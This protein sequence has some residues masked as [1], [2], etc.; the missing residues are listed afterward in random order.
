MGNF[1]LKAK[2]AFK[3]NLKAIMDSKGLSYKDL[4]DMMGL[5]KGRVSALFNSESG[6]TLNT[7]EKV[8]AALSVE[9]TDL[10]DPNFKN[11]LK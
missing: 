7:V 5:T 4:G 9:E 1:S 11:K 6:I 3:L 2:E 10:F 8:A